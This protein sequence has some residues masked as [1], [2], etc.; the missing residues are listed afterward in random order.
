[1]GA[2]MASQMVWEGLPLSFVS[3]EGQE[4][5]LCGTGVA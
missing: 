1:M 5:R 2:L 3:P 4:S